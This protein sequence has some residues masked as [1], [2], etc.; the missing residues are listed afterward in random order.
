MKENHFVHA[1]KLPDGQV[2]ANVNGNG[3][4]ILELLTALNRSV[5]VIMLQA[6]VPAKQAAEIVTRMAG[7]GYAQAEQQF[8]GKTDTGAM[9]TETI[10]VG[11]SLPPERWKAA[12]EHLQVAAPYLAEMMKKINYEGRGQEDFDD[13]M[14]DMTMAVMALAHVA[15][16]A[17]DQ[18][19][20]IPL[21]GGGGGEH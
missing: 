19:R 15:N 5:A 20:F 1:E 8:K 11:Y 9:T 16:F 14:G 18:C 21:Q 17:A 4:T 10:Q 13:F 3:E 12:A 7:A 2:K 6:G